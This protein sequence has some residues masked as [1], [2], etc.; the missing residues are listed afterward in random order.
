MSLLGFIVH[1][2]GSGAALLLDMLALLMVI[3]VLCDW[4]S[5]PI[6]TDFNEAGRPLVDR[7]VTCLAG[8]WRWLVPHRM[9]SPHRGLVVALL[10][11]TA[12]RFCLGVVVSVA[13]RAS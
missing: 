13:V 8:V 12:L 5:I 6:L 7:A 2:L 9:L 3:R 10:F 11:V 4:H 1:T